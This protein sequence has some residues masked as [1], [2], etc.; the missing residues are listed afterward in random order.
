[1]RTLLEQEEPAAKREPVLSHNDVNPGNL[2]YDGERLLLVDWDV[3]GPNDPF[4]DLAA[5]ALFLR[6]DGPTSE[7]LLSAYEGRPVVRLEDR[8]IWNRCLVGVLC[9][10]FFLQSAR[11]N[12]HAGSIAETLDTAP[13]LLECYQRLRAGAFTLGSGEGQWA[14]GLALVK[15]TADRS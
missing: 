13:S 15:E 11:R 10:A 6:M 9:G 12:G 1:M 14:F 2:I 5:A 7:A 3:A 4:Y 8:F